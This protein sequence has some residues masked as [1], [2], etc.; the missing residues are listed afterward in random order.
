MADVTDKAFHMIWADV[1]EDDDEFLA[2][3][4]QPQAQ[5]IL[6]KCQQQAE[7][8]KDLQLP[9]SRSS[10]ADLDSD[11]D[12]DDDFCSRRRQTAIA[13]NRL[14]CVGFL[15]PIE[16]GIAEVDEDEEVVATDD[17]GGS[18]FGLRDAVAISVACSE[19]TDLPEDS[20]EEGCR[21]AVTPKT[22]TT[23]HRAHLQNIAEVA[24]HARPQGAD[25]RI[26]ARQ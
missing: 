8:Q 16:E 2:T 18:E 23:A 13:S 6:E 1:E 7:A 4:S 26:V 20:D 10:W 19:S 3:S 24:R 17:E 14:L 25:A 22:G 9:Q 11:S 21:I 15:P 5:R 12:S